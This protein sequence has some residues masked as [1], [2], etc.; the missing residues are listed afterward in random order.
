MGLL[1][2]TSSKQSGRIIIYGDSN[3]I[4][5][6][7]L[8]VPCYWMLNAMLEYTSTSHLPSIFKEHQDTWNDI[9]E[10][11]VPSRMEKNRLYRY[12]KVLEVNLGEPQPRSLPQCQSLS[13]AQPVPLNMSA[14]S[15]LYQ[16]QRLL[17]LTEGDQVA[18]DPIDNHL[19]GIVI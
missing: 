14:P 11:D 5:T 15:N 3:C 7:H 17:S 18:F 8:E 12:S 9:V 19:K 6:S 2:T 16:S 1:Q 13:W 10:T 4:D